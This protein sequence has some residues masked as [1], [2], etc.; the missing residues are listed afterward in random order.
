MAVI[1]G[2]TL[3]GISIALAVFLSNGDRFMLFLVIWGCLGACMAVAFRRNMAILTVEPHQI[4]SRLQSRVVKVPLHP[5]DRLSV[6]GVRLFVLRHSGTSEEVP[7]NLSLRRWS[8]WVELSAAVEQKWP[9]T[10][11]Q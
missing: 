2:G 10:P 7:L 4:V 3:A 6:V 11:A 5:D 8:D 9:S 1:G